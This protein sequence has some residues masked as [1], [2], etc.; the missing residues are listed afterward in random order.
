MAYLTGCSKDSWAL[1]SGSWL[2]PRLLG[3]AA[4]AV[5]VSEVWANGRPDG[6]PSSS[7]M[8]G[9]ADS[10]RP[11]ANRQARDRE[12]GRM[13]DVERSVTAEPSQGAGPKLQLCSG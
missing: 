13:A 11:A 1:V 10:S 5:W 8:A 12:L 7:A 9:V 3:D 4:G 6:P 2:M